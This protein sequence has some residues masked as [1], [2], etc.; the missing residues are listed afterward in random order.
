MTRE[1]ADFLGVSRPTTIRLLDAG[2]ISFTK[3][4]RH[5]RIYLA[6]LVDYQERQRK[7][8]GQALSDIVADAQAMGD[9]DDDFSQAQEDLTRVSKGGYADAAR[10]GER[11][12]H[13]WRVSGLRSSWLC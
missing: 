8:A 13:K 11:C 2:K 4:N 3:V 1:A 12:W 5:R 9:Y 10:P 6:D 7:V